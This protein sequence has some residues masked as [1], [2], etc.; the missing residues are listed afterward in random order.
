MLDI[1]DENVEVKIGKMRV[2]VDLRNIERSGKGTIKGKAINPERF[3]S[4]IVQ[5][6]LLATLAR[7]GIALARHARR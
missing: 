6:D 3:R 2:K 5:Y 4:G 7:H 1:G